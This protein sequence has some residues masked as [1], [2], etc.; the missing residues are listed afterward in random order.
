MW[1]VPG[2]L[3]D[4]DFSKVHTSSIYCISPFSIVFYL[5]QSSFPPHLSLPANVHD[6]WSSLHWCS[7]CLSFAS[8]CHHH[9]SG[10]R[11]TIKYSFKIDIIYSVSKYRWISD[12]DESRI[13][14]M[15]KIG[16][17]LHSLL[18]V[19]ENVMVNIQCRQQRKCNCC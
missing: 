13:M 2:H 7:Q 8:S 14:F 19:Y 10:V 9:K 4:G 17:L 6:L 16:I 5:W 15:S 18:N 11:I 12:M 1:F 3:C